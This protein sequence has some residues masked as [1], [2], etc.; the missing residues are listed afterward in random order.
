[1]IRNNLKQIRY[2]VDNFSGHAESI[3]QMRSNIFQFLFTVDNDMDQNK[4]KKPERFHPK[5]RY[6]VYTGN[7]KLQISQNYISKNWYKGGVK[8][9]NLLNRH[10]VS[11]NY[12]RNRFQ[13]NNFAEWRVNI[14]TNPNDTF[15]IYR[16]AEDLIR[17]YSDFGL[18]AINN[19]YYS[20]NIEIKT[21]IFNNFAENSK[22][23]IMSAFSPLYINV[24]ILGMRYQ[25]RK[26]YPKVKG[27]E[28]N[29]NADISPLSIKYITVLNR[30]GDINPTNFGIDK[31]KWHFTSFGTTLNA[32]LVYNFNKNVNFNSRFYYFTNYKN[33]TIESE[34]VLNMPINRFFSTN[35]YLF[36]RYD[37]NKNLVKD[38]TFGYLQFNELLSFGFNYHW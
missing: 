38:P 10:D 8:N 18:Q 35:L 23:L 27:K 15:R 29:F 4:K 24:G 25:I 3:K 36:V 11:F 30:S 34:N 33:V 7:H 37:D 14:F 19:W 28:L 2:T 13:I 31:G 16:I 32:R 20:S 17:T 6:W 21:Q 9:L 26:T 5:P 1:L 12:K 22:H